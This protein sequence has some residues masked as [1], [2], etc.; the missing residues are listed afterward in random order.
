MFR[1]PCCT[2][3]TTSRSVIFSSPNNPLILANTASMYRHASGVSDRVHVFVPQAFAYILGSTSLR[4]WDCLLK[5]RFQIGQG[6]IIRAQDNAVREWP[7]NKLLLKLK[8]GGSCVNTTNTIII[9][10]ALLLPQLFSIRSLLDLAAQ[11][12]VD[13]GRWLLSNNGPSTTA[14]TS[15]KQRVEQG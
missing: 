4:H 3:P 11:G 12:R 8:S 6:R 9:V 2:I 10:M 5:P 14:T 15:K 13:A 7:N 1:Q